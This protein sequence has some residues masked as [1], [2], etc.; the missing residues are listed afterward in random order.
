MMLSFCVGIAFIPYSII[1]LLYY[2][3]FENMTANTIVITT[4]S[5]LVLSYILTLILS[6]YNIVE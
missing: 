6:Y 1:T 4:I 3:V 2:Y 5:I